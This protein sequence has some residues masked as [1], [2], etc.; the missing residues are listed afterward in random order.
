MTICSNCTAGT[1]TNSKGATACTSCAAGKVCIAIVLVVGWFEK[2]SPVWDQ[3]YFNRLHQLRHRQIF[4][5]GRQC[6]PGV[7]QWQ[8]CQRDGEIDVHIM[9]PRNLHTVQRRFTVSGL[10]RG[11]GMP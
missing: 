2:R 8:V 9:L 10:R 5:G 1:F 6:L 4:R 3:H 11:Q 7:C